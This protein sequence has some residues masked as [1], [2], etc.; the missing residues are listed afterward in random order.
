[1][2]KKVLIFGVIIVLL[3]LLIPIPHR[4]KDGGTVVYKAITYK[5][6]KV[7]RLDENSETGYRDGL[8]VEI[9]GFKVYNNVK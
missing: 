8:I 5:V 9:L 2:N 3:V 4:L 7:H 1:M 6:L